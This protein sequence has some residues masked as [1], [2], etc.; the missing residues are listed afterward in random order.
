[1][2]Y[3]FCIQNFGYFLLDS[4]VSIFVFFENF[5]KNLFEMS[6]I[7]ITQS[8]SSDLKSPK[9]IGTICNYPTPIPQASFIYQ[10]SKPDEM[11]VNYLLIALLVLVLAIAGCSDKEGMTIGELQEGVE[12]EDSSDESELVSEDE[13]EESEEGT[14]ETDD[15]ESE[16]SGESSE[17]DVTIESEDGERM[18]E[19]EP[20]P[21]EVEVQVQDGLTPVKILVESAT[22]GTAEEGKLEED[23][24]IFSNV[25]CKIRGLTGDRAVGSSYP[26]DI[27]SF[28]LHNRDDRDYFLGYYRRGLEFD[29]IPQYSLKLLI[30]GRKIRDMEEKCGA[31]VIKAGATIE[32]RDVRTVMKTGE[33]FTGR[34][35]DNKLEASGVYMSS[36]TIFT[37]DAE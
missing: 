22:F 32:C 1:M 11:K 12:S 16:E 9:P 24:S 13:S 29:D 6:E 35:N 21:A 25:R 17:D 33:S 3:V 15:A 7:A 28:T 23:V 4:F 18:I 10:Y 31:L 2:L 14:E 19:V 36:K 5:S 30:N 34:P 27:L 26:D 37:C 20:S 8:T